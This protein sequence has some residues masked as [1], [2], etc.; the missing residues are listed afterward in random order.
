[1]GS[2][3]VQG[4]RLLISRFALGAVGRFA[5]RDRVRQVGTE[6]W[7]LTA[8]LVLN[9]FLFWP[10]FYFLGERSTFFPVLETP[11]PTFGIILHTFLIE[12]S[13]LDVFRF[14]LEWFVLLTLWVWIR[15]LRK[16]ALILLLTT[17]YL[18]QFL[19]A[20]YEAFVRSFYL[21]E[22][23]FFTDR[24]LF[25][26]MTRHVVENLNLPLW[27]Y[28][29]LPLLLLLT[30]AF[31]LG[32]FWLT[33]RE[34]SVRRLSR[35]SKVGLLLFT[36]LLMGHTVHSRVDLGWPVS[37]TAS[38]V[39]KIAQNSERS[40]L[41]ATNARRFD[42]GAIAQTIDYGRFP[43][44]DTPN[45]Y[46]IFVESYGSV[47]Y[48]RPDFH[49]AT[50]QLTRELDA[51][52]AENAWYVASALSQSPTWG[53]GSWLAYT[54][55]LSGIR[56][57]THADYLSLM[58]QYYN[59]E[60]PHLGNYL[61][62]QG[63]D[64]YR[65][66]PISRELDDLQWDQYKQFYGF[67]AW[68]RF[69]EMNYS[70]PLYGWGPSP[71]DQYTLNFARDYMDSASDAPHFFFFITQNSHYPWTPLPPIADDWRDLALLPPVA[72][73][74]VNSLTQDQLRQ[75]YMRSIQYEMTALVDFIVR[76]GDENDLFILIGD[77]QPARVARRDDGY[78]TPIHILSQNE[79]LI[80][81]FTDYSFIKTMNVENERPLM[82]HEGLYSLIV[83][84]LVQT[85][86]ENP[87]MLPA[88]HPTGF[89]I[90]P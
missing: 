74:N 89:S 19:Y 86:G 54:S 2:R 48:K 28:A 29:V 22:P 25:S 42:K 31:L 51:R 88:Y 67:D 50:R 83:R 34:E 16:T 18:L 71:S 41:A 87:R 38:V 46:L 57:E 3:R 60:L 82:H 75:N 62:F 85:Y 45:I 20:L 27:A 7:F 24:I 33:F 73:V 4:Y 69:G 5:R 55:A 53:G 90:E 66:S 59:D 80:G 49:L 6:V 79:A 78:D 65:I 63:Y 32:V 17:L 15:P 36:G 43:L 76:A 77:H 10:A 30:M 11:K 37:A 64:T 13:N 44:A 39:A 40:R 14:Q 12:R 26:A 47:L 35:P 58:E 21:L 72:Q 8:V 23:T 56:L 9:F 70:G 1:M 52:L 68:L 81:L 84:S 61:E